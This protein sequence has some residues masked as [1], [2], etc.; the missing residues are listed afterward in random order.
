M[1]AGLQ[2]VGVR[3][4]GVSNAAP[5]A[6][7]VAAETSRSSCSGATQAAVS[8]GGFEAAARTEFSGADCVF[9]MPCGG[10]SGRPSPSEAAERFAS[11][12]LSDAHMFGGGAPPSP[13]RWG[14][15]RAD[16]GWGGESRSPPPSDRGAVRAMLFASKRRTTP[17]PSPSAAPPGLSPWAGSSPAF[18]A[19]GAARSPLHCGESGRWAGADSMFSKPCGGISGRSSPPSRASSALDSH[20]LANATSSSA[21]ASSRGASGRAQSAA[22]APP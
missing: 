5:R 20:A 4:I 18:A 22:K 19:E 8:R 6:A 1:V 13:A 16:P 2:P 10:F 17:H 21:G 11:L 15:G 14:R 7:G 9:S 12:A 3:I